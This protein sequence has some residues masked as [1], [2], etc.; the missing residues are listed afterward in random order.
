[1]KTHRIEQLL[2][3]LPRGGSGR[4]TRPAD[5]HRLVGEGL[6]ATAI[7]HLEESLHLSATE[8]ARILDVSP[9]SRKRFK[10]S[11][12]KRLDSGVSDRLMRVASTIADAADVFGDAEKAIGWFKTRSA[13]LGGATP[14]ELMTSDPG[15]GLVR[16][17]LNRIRY[18]HWA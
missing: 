15:A 7:S 6:P 11:P 1:M 8:S 17:E 12:R 16:E 9:S 10:K 13:A 5:L 14:L 2:G 18:G 3:L 4:P